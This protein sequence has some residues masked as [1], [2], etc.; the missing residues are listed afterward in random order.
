VNVTQTVGT[1]ISQRLATLHELQT[2]YSLEDALDMLEVISVDAYN[3]NKAAR[4]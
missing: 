3:H 2:I 1:I 4:H